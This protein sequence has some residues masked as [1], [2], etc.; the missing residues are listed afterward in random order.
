MTPVLSEKQT[1]KLPKVAVV[2]A[3]F[4]GANF[5]LEQLVSIQAQMGVDVTIFVSDDCSSDSTLSIISDFM[6][7]KIC[8]MNIVILS[9]RVKYGSAASNFLHT[10][11]KTP[12]EEYDYVCFSDQD[13]IWLPK[14]LDRAIT[15]MKRESSVGYS[16]NI[17]SWESDTGRCSLI[18]KDDAQSSCDFMF[19]G[20]GPGCTIVMAA[21]ESE[22]LIRFLKDLDEDDL[23]HIWFHDWFVYS[24]FRARKY[25]WSIDRFTGL[26]YRQHADNVIGANIG[27]Y[28]MMN[29]LKLLSR[30]KEETLFLAKII[31]Y[32]EQLPVFR[33][34]WLGVYFVKKPFS[35][36]RKFSEGAM[37]LILSLFFIL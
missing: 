1:L 14:K 2:M 3:T 21:C 16:S 30:W 33:I 22:T 36:R 17:I 13:D 10:L 37:L 23:K 11:M 25:S 34:D 15:V 12:I 8:V 35:A 9:E 7:S 29:R 20:S 27:F 32:S 26:L 19:Q 5:I 6:K 28:S 4:N 31:G 24:F 18:K